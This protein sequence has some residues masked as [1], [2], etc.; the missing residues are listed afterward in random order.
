MAAINILIVLFTAP[1]SFYKDLP[2]V[3]IKGKKC[4]DKTEK[5]NDKHV[6][7]L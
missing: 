2:K 5:R 4:R 6:Q 7:I 3:I 1:F